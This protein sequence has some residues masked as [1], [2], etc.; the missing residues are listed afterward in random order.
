MLIK[1][2]SNPDVIINLRDG[3]FIEQDIDLYLQNYKIIFHKNKSDNAVWYF[4]SEKECKD[5]FNSIKSFA[6]EVK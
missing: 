2:V 1:N 3:F 6:E 4:N 5:C